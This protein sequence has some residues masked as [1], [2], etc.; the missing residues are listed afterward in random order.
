V[1]DGQPYFVVELV[2]YVMGGELAGKK[3]AALGLSYK[4]N[5]DDLRESPAVTVVQLLA[6]SGAAVMAYEPYKLDVQ[7]PGVRIVP[8]LN[9]A[10]NEADLILLLV[11]HDK[12][13]ELKPSS[14]IE[15]SPARLIVDASEVGY[16]DKLEFQTAGF[17]FFR[18]G[19]GKTARQEKSIQS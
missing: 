17:G 3:I 12:F 11:G 15:L 8:N 4:A 5:V 1:N 6:Q 14:L 7:I 10:L 19:D 18:L 13:R 9:D 16:W 2:E